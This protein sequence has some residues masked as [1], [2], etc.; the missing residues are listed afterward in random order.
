LN[1]LHKQALATQVSIKQLQMREAAH[2]RSVLWSG[3]STLPEV[4]TSVLGA[5]VVLM[6]ALTLLWRYLW[7]RHPVRRVDRLDT[8]IPD[9][10]PAVGVRYVTRPEVA[11]SPVSS[12]TP[13]AA[14]TEDTPALSPGP[15]APRAGPWQEQSSPFTRP[16][17]AT[18]FDSEAAAS[19][20]VRVRKSLAEKR[21]A[22]A[23]LFD[24][25][26]D[27]QQ[28]ESKLWPDD[29]V[30]FLLPLDTIEAGPASN[31]LL[32][33]LEPEDEPDQAESVQSAFLQSAF[34]DAMAA[35]R[36]VAQGPRP[37]APP[38]PPTPVPESEPEPELEPEH[39]TTPSMLSQSEPDPL[40]ELDFEQYGSADAVKLALAE[41]SAMLG[42]W[43]EARELANE[44]MESGNA[45]LNS[46]AQN[47]LDKL[48]QLERELTK[49]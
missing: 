39:E 42:L 8:L 36:P 34:D 32:G 33:T 24:R 15:V 13:L 22:R 20:V 3:L 9:M 10:P 5:F 41:E 26:D 25:A 49:K 31:G 46:Q 21:E 18:G 7:R 35:E 2:S 11:L 37:P 48:N 29:I 23:Q 30:S 43:P 4:D 27:A 16:D 14:S 38:P 6:L 40:P 19:E 45:L 47:L 44:A 28:S 17:P 12:L 1:A